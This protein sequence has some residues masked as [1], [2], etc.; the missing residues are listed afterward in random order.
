MWR[1]KK[2]FITF[3]TT[4]LLWGSLGYLIYFTAPSTNSIPLF[5]GGL[6]FAL[7][8]TCA[9]ILG[10]SRRGLL[11]G[12]LA[13]TSLLLKYLQAF[14]FLTVLLLIAFLITIE[15]ILSKR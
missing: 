3:I 6:F 12:I 14:N 7:F 4:L 15:L 9:L 1:R 13:T 8:I 5:F 11:I 2:Y 10:N